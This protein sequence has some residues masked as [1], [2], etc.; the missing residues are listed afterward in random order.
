MTNLMNSIICKFNIA[1]YYLF[2]IGKKVVK[3]KSLLFKNMKCS[4]VLHSLSSWFLAQN[5]RFSTRGS[6]LENLGG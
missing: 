1:T 6:S 3:V 4:K 5:G 2:L